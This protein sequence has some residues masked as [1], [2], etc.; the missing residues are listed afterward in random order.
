MYLK[1][2]FSYEITTMDSTLRVTALTV[3]KIF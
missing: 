3:V 2:T 1:S